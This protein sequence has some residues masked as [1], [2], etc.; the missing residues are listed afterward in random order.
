MQND[1]T[2]SSLSTYEKSKMAEHTVM[3]KI[4]FENRFLFATWTT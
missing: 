4:A 2:D 1:F 3:G